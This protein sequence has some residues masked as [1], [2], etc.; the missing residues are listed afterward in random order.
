[1]NISQFK[2]SIIVTLFTFPIY[3]QDLNIFDEG[4]LYVMP[5][6]SVYVGENLSISS[7]NIGFQFF[8]LK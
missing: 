4:L 5:N 7:T 1:M 6:S 3:A 8:M 2:L